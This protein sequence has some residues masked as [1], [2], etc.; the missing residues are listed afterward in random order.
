M[1][2]E[3]AASLALVALVSFGGI[4][5]ADGPT[6]SPS[7]PAAAT[8]TV[9]KP[10]A[11]D[12]NRMVCKTEEITGSRLEGHRTCMTAADWDAKARQGRENLDDA[13]ARAAMGNNSPN[14]AGG[15]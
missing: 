6:P 9:K 3:V 14:L 5:L 12:P 2:K 11:H 7:A 10:S 15:H 13:E 1:M 4:A 8:A